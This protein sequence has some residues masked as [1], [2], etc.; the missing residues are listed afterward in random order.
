MEKLEELAW[1]WLT[2]NW[3]ITQEDMPNLVC[4]PH[5]SMNQYVVEFYDSDTDKVYHEWFIT[6]D[7]LKQ[8]VEGKNPKKVRNQYKK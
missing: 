8:L 3:K 1:N 5:L 6:S 7:M 2:S 4:Y